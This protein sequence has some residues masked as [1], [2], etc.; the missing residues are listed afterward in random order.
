M[1][2]NFSKHKGFFLALKHVYNYTYVSEGI[3]SL[4]HLK[5]KKN[6]VTY[7][8]EC[9]SF[10]NK[11]KKKPDSK[12]ICIGKLDPETEQLIPSKRL[13]GPKQDA[14]LTENTATIKIVGTTSLFDHIAE[15]LEL[16]S[17]LRKSF[18]D[19]WQM[20]LS[21]AYFQT[22]EGKPLSRAEHW[23]KTHQHPYDPFIDNRRISELLP[24]ITEEK[25][26]GFF[27]KWAEKRLEDEYLA[28]DITSVSS[29]SDLNEMVRYGYNRDGENLPQVNLAMLF[30]EK[31]R[32]PIYYKSLPGSIRD[33]S[34]VHN[35]LETA[36][37]LNKKKIRLVMDKGFYS[38]K[39]INDLL[40]RRLKFTIAIPFSSDLA[41]DHVEKARSTITDHKNFKKIGDQNLFYTSFLTKWDGKNRIYVHV[42]YNA[43][44][45]TADYESF[46]NKMSQ[47]EEELKNG[48]EVEDNQK[49]YDKYFYVKQTP[50]RGRQI[51]YNQTAIDQYKKNAAG[52]LVLLT[53]DLKDPIE[54]LQ[55]YRNKDVVE[56]AFDNLKNGL[57]MNRLRVHLQENMRGRFFIQFIALILLSYIHKVVNEKDLSK[58]GSIPCLL[59][60]LEL[61]H[62]I[63]FQGKTS[64]MTSELTK[65]QREIFKAFDIDV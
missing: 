15:K 64:C 11:E 43:S 51:S 44:A 62:T 45:A 30:G 13:Q 5:N 22:I 33:V 12:R 24:T 40:S 2:C 38:S 36:A 21:L 27:K 58:L 63:K 20:I 55:T 41:N 54:A 65:K 59:E 9:H 26:L 14:D 37:F 56:K 53:N 39:N 6:G 47:W 46:L 50:K 57:D 34:T 60:E 16:K 42:Y 31:T 35:F 32:L 3:M 61:L 17:I 48:K 4:I 23:S 1:F 52:Y 29:Y 28:Y 25:Q 10:W 49:H 8:Y 18:P 19:D 7:V